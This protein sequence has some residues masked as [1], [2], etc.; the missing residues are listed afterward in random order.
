MFCVSPVG[1]G[2][3]I[4]NSHDS[5]PRVFS[6]NT[7]ASCFGFG[8]GNRL[9]A[10]R[11]ATKNRIQSVGWRVEM[12]LIQGM[13]AKQVGVPTSRAAVLLYSKTAEKKVPWNKKGTELPRMPLA[14]ESISP[15]MP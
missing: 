2:C 9:K 14:M 8:I 4:R 3:G 15:A 5:L 7:E 6:D 11:A 12:G 1:V 10:P 13:L